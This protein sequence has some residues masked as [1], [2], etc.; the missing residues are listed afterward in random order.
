MQ[1]RGPPER[2][3]RGCHRQMAAEGKVATRPTAIAFICGASMSLHQ[4]LEVFRDPGHLLRSALDRSRPIC[5]SDATRPLAAAIMVSQCD[6]QCVASVSA[7]RDRR[8]CRCR[9]RLA[10]P[11]AR[12]PPL[13]AAD[14]PHAP[15]QRRAAASLSPQWCRPRSQ[16]GLPTMP[17]PRSQSIRQQQ[18]ALH[19]RRRH[20]QPTATAMQHRHQRTR[21]RRSK[22]RVWLCSMKQCMTMHASPFAGCCPVLLAGSSARPALCRKPNS[23][24]SIPPPSPLSAV[25]YIQQDR[26]MDTGTAALMGGAAGLMTGVLLAEATQ[27]HYGWY[28]PACG[29]T[30]IG[31]RAR[32]LV[33]WCM[34]ACPMRSPA[35]ATLHA[36][37][38][39][40]LSMS[41]R[42][43]PAPYVPC[44][45][46]YRCCHCRCTLR[47]CPAAQHPA[48]CR[49]HLDTSSCR[50]REHNHY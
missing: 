36:W 31:A 28:G 46:A 41:R 33:V 9:C 16:C 2:L 22:V 26:G 6:K 13:L 40:L 35:S 38:P 5:A 15:F 4:I 32:G 25:T 45:A 47:T 21:T 3:R 43:V 20:P 23:H 18:H 34:V 12:L 44:C 19:R 50:C 24:S 11:V 39:W 49:C 48:H 37:L 10:P 29:P 1:R 27:P 7:A 14:P 30:V 42:R 8:L 17:A